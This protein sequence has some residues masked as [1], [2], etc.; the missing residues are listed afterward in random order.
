MYKRY[1]AA[2]LAAIALPLSA[3]AQAQKI[4]I[5]QSTPLTGS[6]AE[7]GKDIRDGANAYFRKV[8]EA[9]G[10]NGRQ[11]E[12]LSLDDKNDRKTAGANAVKLVNESHV[13]AL[14]GFASATLSLDAMPIVKEKGVPFFA[15]FTGADAIHKQNDHVFVMRASY[16]DELVKIL[17]HWGS[18]G[19]DR[20]TV[21]H[22]DDE[23]G[24][25]NFA[26]VE[27]IL[28]A[29][30]KKA[31][32]VKVQ[33]N[34]PL[35]DKAIQAIIKSDPQ[36]IVATTLYGNTSELLK[37]L[38]AAKL[39]YNVTSLSFVGP[40]QLAKAAGAD[41]AGV[42]VAG[43]VPPPTKKVVPVISECGD[44]VK[45]AGIPELNYTNLEACIAAKVLV[46]AIRRAGS[47]VTREGLY[48]ALTGIGTYD[49]GG[50]T[51]SFSPE[52]RHGSHYVE[53]AVIGKNGQ[54]R[55]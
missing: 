34:A 49:A 42:S 31:V 28:K 46:E 55:F 17:E 53:L 9:G 43:V 6:N 38:K 37:G 26:T 19:A 29:A 7:I 10:I 15:P 5:G 51:V 22:Y 36:V 44:A 1:A 21:L 39:P 50:Y 8:N 16:A 33:R 52:S 11:I 18:L 40:S 45:K 54:F 23:I 27:R 13:L 3:G 32:S 14:F 30:N 2:A 12:M 41:A 20:V 48:K 24:N 25:Q 4:L 35:D 47:N